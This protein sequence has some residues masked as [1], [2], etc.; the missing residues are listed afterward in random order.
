MEG[1][2][3]VF[4]FPFFSIAWNHKSKSI[5]G[6]FLE[7]ST[8]FTVDNLYEYDTLQPSPPHAHHTHPSEQTKLPLEEQTYLDA[9]VDSFVCPDEDTDDDADSFFDVCDVLPEA[10]FCRQDSIQLSPEEAQAEHDI[11]VFLASS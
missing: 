3:R 9:Q 7:D 8:F 1:S 10:V 4:R 6:F 5:S 11:G 2:Y